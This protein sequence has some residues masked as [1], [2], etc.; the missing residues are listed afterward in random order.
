MLLPTVQATSPANPPAE[1][2]VL[3]TVGAIAS[4]TLFSTQP[5]AILR[6][7]P[8]GYIDVRAIEGLFGGFGS[9]RVLQLW[10]FFLLGAAAGLAVLGEGVDG[11]A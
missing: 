10:K 9:T 8:D 4:E 5:V 11:I 1:D 6:V 2:T 7:D 3:E